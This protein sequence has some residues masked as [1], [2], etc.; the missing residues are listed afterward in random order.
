MVDS[1]VD[2]KKILSLIVLAICSVM[3]MNAEKIPQGYYNRLNGTQ[4]SVLK[5]TL[6]EIIRP[7]TVVPYGPG[8]GRTWEVFY[9]SDRD[10]VSNLCMDMYCD[11]WREFSSVGSVAP[12]CNI[13]HSVAKSWW[14]GTQMDAYYDCYHLNPSNSTANSTRSNYPLGE[15]E[16]GSTT[17]GASFKIG[18]MF[19]DSLGYFNVFEPKAEYKGDFARAYFYIA[20]CYGRDLNGNYPDLGANSKKNYKGWRVDNASVGSRF[21]MQNNNYLEFQQWYIELLLKW[22]RE[23]PVSAKERHRQDAVSD[24]QHNRNPYIDHPELVEYI[25]GDKKG[26]KYFFGLL[27]GGSALDE[28]YEDKALKAEKIIKN[29][30]LYIQYDGVLYDLCGQ[31]VE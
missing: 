16:G 8:A 7:H 29:G 26:K 13:E 25:W 27:T 28:T 19:S 15:V 5:G 3:S 12:G 10:T 9:Y 20:T 18:T 11:T 4:D 1:V 17:N 31:V 24:F 6:R 22:H 30:R 23:D 14:G 21:A 2:M